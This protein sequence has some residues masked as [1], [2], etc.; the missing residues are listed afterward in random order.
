MSTDFPGHPRDDLSGD[1]PGE[2]L[3]DFVAS[4]PGLDA[5]LGMLTADATLDELADEGAALAMFR[6]T[7]SRSRPGSPSLAAPSGDSSARGAGYV[8]PACQRPERGRPRGS[9]WPARRAGL[10][11]AAVTLAA[12]AG[13]AVA[14][15]T[16]ALP[17]PLQQAAYQMLRFAGVPAAHHSKP[18]ATSPS[19][20]GNTRGRAPEQTRPLSV[21]LTAAEQFG[22]GVPDRAG[23]P[24]PQ[25]HQRADRCRHE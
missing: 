18:A 23:E 1:V 25:R 9:C 12:A 4:E 15:Y 11:A 17:T 8:H 16:A 6:R 19:P 3:G 13:F 22:P 24:V 7:D 14:A 2:H 20:P 5:L 21:G 10:M